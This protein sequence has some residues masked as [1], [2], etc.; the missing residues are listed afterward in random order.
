MLRQTQSL[1]AMRLFVNLYDEHNLASDGGIHWR[2]IRRTYERRQVGESGQFTV[3]G[4]ARSIETTWSDLPTVRDFLTGKYV[5]TPR[6]GGGV[7]KRDFGLPVFWDAW[8]LL[9]RLGLVQIVGHLVEADNDDAELIHPCAA[10]EGE[11]F[12]RDLA[13]AANMAGAALLTEGQRQW[14]AEHCIQLVPVASHIAAVQMVGLARLRYRP[15]TKATAAWAAAKQ[16]WADFQQRYEVIAGSN[17]T[18]LQRAKQET[19]V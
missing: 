10:Q 12:E 15:R 4:F 16:K 7:Y 17:G 11:Q 6:E 13:F 14:A 5:K 19:V 3:W 8:G 9:K 2:R 1:A 18:Q